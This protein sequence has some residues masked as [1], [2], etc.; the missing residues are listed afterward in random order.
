LKKRPEQEKRLRLF[1]VSKKRKIGR[2][3]LQKKR[4]SVKK[5]KKLKG[6][7]RKKRKER[8]RRELDL[9]KR[10][11]LPSKKGLEL[12]KRRLLLKP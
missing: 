2:D 8:S 10:D 1:V 5:W 11:S 7:G 12:K 3:R 6:R 4:G 9:K